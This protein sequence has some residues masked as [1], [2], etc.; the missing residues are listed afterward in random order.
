MRSPLRSLAVLAFV[1]VAVFA[2]ARCFAA[3]SGNPAPPPASLVGG[4]VA[5]GNAAADVSHTPAPQP[6]PPDA[7]TVV[8]PGPLRSFLRMAGI[9]QQVPNEDVLPMLARNVA[10][11]GHESG[12]E[13]E[14]LVLLA[15]YVEYARQLQALA[16]PDNTIRVAD[17][18]DAIH[19]V[20]VLGYQFAQSC[21]LKGASLVT[22]N[23][24]RAFLT[25]DSGF[26]LTT[27]EQ[28]LEKHV[29][30]TY[31]FPGTRVPVL[32][33][34]KDWVAIGGMKHKGGT[35][36]LDIL[37][38]DVDVDRL[39]TGMAHLD[40]QTRLA[41]AHAPG[42]RR[43][44]P[45]SAVF[46]FYGSQI[47]IRSGQVQVPGGAAAERNW[48]D[49][50]GASTS[51]SGEFVDHLLER[52]RGWLAAYFDALSRVGPAQ[53]ARLTDSGHLRALYTAYRSP[54]ANEYASAGVFPKNAELLLLFTR[55]QWDASGQPVVPG[56][57]AVWSQIFDKQSRT[58]GFRDWSRHMH[59]ID[60]PDHLLEGLV[61]AANI[62][63]DIG[64]LQVYLSLSAIVSGRQPGSLPS[65]A[66]VALLADN[67]VRF[68][69]WFAIFAEFPSLDDSSIA[70]FVDAADRVD[71]IS[72]QA[73]R[74]N[75]LGS[76]QADIGLWQIFARQGQIPPDKINTSW[77]SAIHPFD[78]FSSS[79]QLFDA[80][81][82]SLEAT[83]LA[84]SGKSELSQD[85]I[86]ELLAGPAQK[87][88][89][90]RR[91]HQELAHRIGAVLDDQRLVSLDTLFG[92]YDGLNQLAHGAH[93][94]DSLLPLAG[95]L[96]EF[97]MPRPIFTEGEKTSWSPVIY[98]NRHA[99]LQIRT[100]LTS[101]IRTPGTPAQLEA[102]RGRL[103]PF[104][105]DTL[106]GLNY[107]Y[108]E[109]PGA[110]VLHNN[111]LFVRSHDF[112][113]V[114]VQGVQEIWGPPELIGIGVT[115]GGG[116]YLM[117][118]LADLPYALAS[119]EQDFIAPDNVQALIWKETVPQLLV[120][121]VIPRW[122]NITPSE[123]HAAALYQRAGDELLVAASGNPDLHAKVVSIL[124]DRVSPERLARI[125]SALN[126]P[127]P[128]A[129]LAADSLPSVTFYLAAT[130]RRQFPGQAAQ[131]GPAGKELDD[132][133]RTDPDDTT[134]A[135]LARD[136]GVPH[137]EMAQSDACDLIDTGLFPVSG[138]YTSR[139]FGESWQSTNLYWARLADEMGYS[140]VALNV[141][142][143]QLTRAMIVNIFATNIDDWPALY[144]AMEQTGEEF[145]QGRIAVEAAGPAHGQ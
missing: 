64:P 67:F 85:Q 14:F 9:S 115:A 43:L 109:P 108:Y 29:P 132:L 42:L 48:Q 59:P 135:R 6:L 10:L 27:L 8:I 114:S 80:A 58:A 52:D 12:R 79:G 71:K 118:S 53:Q 103:A 28:D 113:T 18:N 7:E 117:G 24:E 83:L 98:T 131:W 100:D 112:S 68:N 136:F 92:L 72:N 25:L 51:N 87:T 54:A 5:E 47:C 105:R 86:V 20:E 66:T 129:A 104:L 37:L 13:T 137:P 46:D 63:T 143:P 77:Q 44:L 94:A 31:E 61:S 16:G 4:Y 127:Q 22:G 128:S 56:D 110:Q 74:A 36:I 70:S 19:V 69:N 2:V 99:E 81:R 139:L 11:W 122:W 49:L 76:F 121:A 15:R 111:P 126:Q 17:C 90:G 141:L 30:F 62:E 57:I 107:A 145:K 23:A 84:A 39:Y 124:A 102:A 21:G 34:E 45:V 119:V 95:D 130:Y 125:E 55:L 38:H 88:P 3:H 140:P 101:V 78:A 134:P 138:G 40:P 97:E 82:A 123:L 91:V 33:S 65:S 1:L 93:V 60:S 133:I 73:L 106:V 41:L 96:R 144:R 89:E 26:P 32:F 35:D 142:V 75:A 50:V 120:D 116:A